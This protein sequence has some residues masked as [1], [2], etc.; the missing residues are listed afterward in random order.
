MN[1][2]S[3]DEQVPKDKLEE[4]KRAILESAKLLNEPDIGESPLKCVDHVR[5]KLTE[6]RTKKCRNEGLLAEMEKIGGS[7]SDTIELLRQKLGVTETELQQT[8]AAIEKVEEQ[9]KRIESQIS[10]LKRVSNRKKEMAETLGS[11]QQIS[12][13]AEIAKAEGEQ[14]RQQEMR[15]KAKLAELKQSNIAELLAEEKTKQ[16]NVQNAI[17][18][19]RAEEEKK[20]SARHIYLSEKRRTLRQKLDDL[21]EQ[22]RVFLCERDRVTHIREEIERF[23]ALIARES[24]RPDQTLV[25]EEERPQRQVNLDRTSRLVMLLLTDGPKPAI[26]QCLGEELDWSEKQAN[27]FALLTQKSSKVGWAEWLRSLVEE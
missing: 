5:R 8:K 10:D 13:Q 11:I 18:A 15:L 2:D 12:E 1:D 17:D 22:K 16:M 4:C 24:K 27:E 3:D 9:N 14:L 20:S 26:I 21:A 19:L 6:Q 25:A 7:R 23:H